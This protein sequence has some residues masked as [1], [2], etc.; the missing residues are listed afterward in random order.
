MEKFVLINCIDNDV[1]VG[2]S[3]IIRYLNTEDGDVVA[4]FKDYNFI[5]AVNVKKQ[6][7]DDYKDMYCDAKIALVNKSL[8]EMKLVAKVAA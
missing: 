1:K 3:V 5:G 8:N 4:V 6:S 7:V 2:D